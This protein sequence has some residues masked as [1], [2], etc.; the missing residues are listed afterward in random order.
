MSTAVEAKSGYSSIERVLDILLLFAGPSVVHSA[1]SIG[2]AMGVSRSSTYRYLNILRSKGLIE[3]IDASGEYR[4]GSG[5]VRMVAASIDTLTPTAA[6]EP[7]VAELAK[8]VGE[9]TLFTVRVG[10]RV[11]CATY[12]ESP[13]AVRVSIDPVRETPIHIGSSARVHLAYLADREQGKI[14]DALAKA[15]S[16]AAERKKVGALPAELKAIREAGVARSSGEIESGVNSMS[17]PVFHPS[18]AVAGVLTIAAPHFRMQSLDGLM[19]QLAAA[20]ARIEDA[21]AQAS[22]GQRAPESAA[23]RRAR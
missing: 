18:G 10:H 1:Q 9:T 11:Q 4:L 13:K 16:S 21:L 6:A 2:D 3:E 5:F 8:A 15:A 23:L 20:A 14:L 12:T 22:G 19:P 17:V 7:V